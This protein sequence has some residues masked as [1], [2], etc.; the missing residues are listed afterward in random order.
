MYMALLMASVISILKLIVNSFGIVNNV[1]VLYFNITY[2]VVDWFTLVQLFGIVL[3][4][5]ILSFF[6]FINWTPFRTQLLMI[7]TFKLF[8]CS[9]LVCAY[10][11]PI[12]F[13]LIYICQFL[14]GLSSALCVTAVTTFA[15]NWCPK[16]KIGTAISI[17]P[18][19][20][21]VGSILG[22]IIP[23]HLFDSPNASNITNASSLIE[24]DKHWLKNT[25]KCFL[26]SFIPILLF[27]I[28]LLTAQYLFV[29][30][31]GNSQQNH[32]IVNLILFFAAI[33]PKQFPTFLLQS[34]S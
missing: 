5:A 23:S 18:L 7:T 28:F 33:Q 1:Y 27:C 13:P 3:A 31:N 17:R 22:Y 29:P 34:K 10:A 6:I 20:L 15:I 30:K 11:K 19:S 32:F 14:I 26:I 16:N 24:I 8:A 25:Q 21:G 2:I 9:C 12:T 4:S